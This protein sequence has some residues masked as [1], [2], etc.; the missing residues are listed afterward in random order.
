MRALLC[1]CGLRLEAEDDKALL[2]S[3]RAHLV[4][5]HPTI[6]PTDEQVREIVATRAYNLE[7]AE[8]Y[9]NALDSEDEFGP[10]PY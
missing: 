5:R 3:V 10:E 4:R 8:L 7:Y 9:A 6:P 2:A 1:H